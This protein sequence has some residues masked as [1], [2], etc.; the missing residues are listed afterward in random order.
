MTIDSPDQELTIL[1]ATTQA[2]VKII[3]TFK[4]SFTDMFGFVGNVSH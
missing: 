1:E 3:L 2:V 4:N